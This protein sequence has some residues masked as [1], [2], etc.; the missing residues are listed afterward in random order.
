MPSGYWKVVGVEDRGDIG[1]AAF[2][3]DQDRATSDSHCDGDKAASVGE[4]ETR[5][6]LKFMYWLDRGLYEALEVTHGTLFEELGW[7]WQ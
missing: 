7:R 3:F 2:V 6:G 1:L 5:T 4:V